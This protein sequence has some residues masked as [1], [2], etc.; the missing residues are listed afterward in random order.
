MH[1]GFITLLLLLCFSI[2][3]QAQSVKRDIFAAGETIT[4]DN[5]NS[6]STI[7]QSTNGIYA[8]DGNIVKVGFRITYYK[9]DEVA[10]RLLVWR[11]QMLLMSRL[12]CTQLQPLILFSINHIRLIQSNL[13]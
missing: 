12:N 4:G 9:K 13:A 2:I 1:R 3:L 5:K 11:Q 10:P 8:I 7:G 6:K